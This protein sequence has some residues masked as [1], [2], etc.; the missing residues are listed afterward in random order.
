MTFKAV[1]FVFLGLLTSALLLL[2]APSVRV[3]L[4]LALAIWSFC[5]VYYFAF[6]AIEHYVD[7]NYRFSGLMSFARFYF[8]EKR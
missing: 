8:S 4:L 5:R 3:A 7:G 1:L 6:Y 2:E